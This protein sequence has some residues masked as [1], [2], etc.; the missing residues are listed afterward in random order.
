[1]LNSQN[2]SRAERTFSY[3]LKGG[4]LLTPFLVLVV[5]RSMYFPFITGKNFAFRILIEILAAV[6][7]VAALKFPS[8]RPRSSAVTWA[9]ISF[10][11]IMGLATIF[12]LSPY[13]S[14]WSSFERMDGYL[15][16]LH[17][18]FYFLLLASVFKDERDWVIFLYTS[19]GVSAIVSFYAVMQLAGKFN[20]HQGGTRVDATF[21][22]AT[23]L[24]AY[25]LFH[26]FFIIWF[27]LR[28]SSWWARLGW[29]ALFALEAVI[30]YNTATRGAI[31]GLL[32]GLFV[33]AVLLAVW[34]RG[35]LR[36]WAIAGLAFL[37]L[38][39]ILFFL[40]KDTSPVKK[41]PVLERFAGI[42]L[43]ETTTQSRFT[44]WKMAL[45][46]WRERPVIGWGQE[47]FIY[48]FSKYY[49][50]SLWRQ[51]PW[52]DR[53][54]NI[55]L[56]WLTAGGILGLVSYLAIYSASLWILF[57][58]FR[59]RV[60][61]VISFAVLI[62]LLLAHFFQ[63]IFVFDNLTSYL[64][65]FAVVAYVHLF[66]TELSAVPAGGEN[67]A[68]EKNRSRSS[69]RVFRA[70]AGLVTAATAVVGILVVLLLYFANIKPILA[71]Q[72]ILSSLRIS[73][74]HAP[75][76][77]VDALIA[78][79]KNGLAM[80]TFG[81]AEAREQISQ[82][83]NAVIGD[84]ALA[85]Q[86]K[87]KY[88]DFAIRE[89]ENQRRSF[90]T[91]VRAK[92]FLSTLYSQAGRPNEALEVINE[93]LEISRKRPQFFFIAGEVY[94]NAGQSVQAIEAIRTAY[95]L[96]PDYPEA[97][98]N[99]AIILILGGKDQEVEGLF[100]K[101]FGV[102]IFPAER[103]AKAYIS[104]GKLDKA[105]FIREEIVRRSPDNAE[106]RANLGSL[107][108]QLRQFDKAIREF[109]EAIRLEPRFKSSGEQI[110]RQIREGKVQ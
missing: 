39:P 25:L 57:W 70:P 21:G 85:E 30:L 49:E 82:V 102:K 89:M 78:S 109:E 92:A 94:S 18:F 110:I 7:A 28:A 75:A 48:V 46:G 60:I 95:E 83:A 1:M 45:Q 69:G 4:L 55:F 64:L 80:K 86:D 72:R 10:L 74:E 29:A 66:S 62:S 36:R 65:F 24:A 91:D 61:D 100:E 22:N 40:V 16:L 87:V 77:K 67:R 54:H 96:A 99:Y 8:F 44:I 43:Q 11:A 6:W 50:P 68:A 23:Y 93:A 53:A 47:S 14:F 71:A 38:V 20:I 33:M 26:I 41:S 88:F 98:S 108:V 106:H 17:L 2:M 104:A 73:N 3:I 90:P 107:Y 52:F 27:F 101:H 19:L 42:S 103:Y 63:N 56:D 31:I 58:S 37:V 97:I 81:T 9:V 32:G 59:R 79:F 12:S 84:P 76:G 34:A 105:L 35:P 13:K 5:T 51:E 15:G